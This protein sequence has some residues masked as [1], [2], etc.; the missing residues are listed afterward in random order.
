MDKKTLRNN[1]KNFAAFSA[2]LVSSIFMAVTAF[3]WFGQDFR[4]YHAAA[5][6]ILV[7]GNP[8]DHHELAP[9]LLRVTGK[10]GNNP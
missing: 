6:V 4:G 1:H 3:Q 7:G 9:M 5:R 8:Y 10:M 2:W